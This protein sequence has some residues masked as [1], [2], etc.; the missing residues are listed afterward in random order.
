MKKK[1]KQ[2]QKTKK[3]HIENFCVFKVIIFKKRVA[4][5]KCKQAI[6]N[7]PVNHGKRVLFEGSSTLNI[8]NHIKFQNF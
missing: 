6:N 2:E 4:F 7:D 1:G 8:Q 3:I 5:S